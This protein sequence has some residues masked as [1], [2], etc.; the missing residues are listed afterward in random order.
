MLAHLSRFPLYAV[1]LLAMR[2]CQRGTR[3]QSRQGQGRRRHPDA[4][5]EHAAPRARQVPHAL[6]K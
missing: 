1:L 5:N 4:G 2:S 3:A 6:P